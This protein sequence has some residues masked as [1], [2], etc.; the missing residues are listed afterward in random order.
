MYLCH[1]TY[2]K[3]TTK[4]WTTVTLH[5]SAVAPDFKPCADQT[6]YNH[7]IKHEYIRVQN[8]EVQY[9]F[10]KS[11][12]ARWRQRGTTRNNISDT[13]GHCCNNTTQ[14]PLLQQ[15]EPKVNVPIMRFKV[16]V[17]TIW[18]NVSYNFVPQGHSGNNVM[19]DAN[20]RS[21]RAQRVQ[22]TNYEWQGSQRR[23]TR[24]PWSRR[25]KGL[26]P[27]VNACKGK[28]S[29]GQRSRRQAAY[30]ASLRAAK[31]LTGFPAVCR[32]QKSPV[33]LNGQTSAGQ[34]GGWQVRVGPTVTVEAKSVQAQRGQRSDG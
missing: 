31:E 13:Q 11:H 14:R 20:F 30:W 26:G 27:S 18:T 7:R 3:T 32:L 29:M 5:R 25:R 6:K 4:R 22:S 10:N 19:N 12:H 28:T 23:G 2:A 8:T 15:R 9:V 24:R 17:S 1:K 16:T 21:E 34:Y 33:S